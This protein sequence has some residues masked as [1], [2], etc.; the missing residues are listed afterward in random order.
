MDLHSCLFSFKENFNGR[1]EVCLLN[2]E[3]YD[4]EMSDNIK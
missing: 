3:D 1:E 4:I 2:Y